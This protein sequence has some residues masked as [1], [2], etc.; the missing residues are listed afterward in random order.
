MILD[1]NIPGSKN[2]KMIS[3]ITKIDP[4]LK[5][6]VFSAYEESVGIQYIKSRGSWLC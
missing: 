3:E 5:I 4:S 1:I 6:L 2:I